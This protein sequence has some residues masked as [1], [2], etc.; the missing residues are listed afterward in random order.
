MRA[1][2]V[3]RSAFAPGRSAAGFR[4]DEIMDHG[5]PHA[6]VAVVRIP[7]CILHGIL[8]RWPCFSLLG[9]CWSCC[10]PSS[11]A[12]WAL[13][14]CPPSACL[15]HFAAELSRCRQSLCVCVDVCVCVQAAWASRRDVMV[16]SVNSWH[17]GDRRRLCLPAGSYP[18]PG[19][20]VFSGIL[21]MT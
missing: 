13:V 18:T 1:F 10:L 11:A 3:L 6:S 4:C 7:G 20:V 8:C 15:Q 17:V 21:H 5:C 16:S 2:L 9:A 12:V 14:P 19:L